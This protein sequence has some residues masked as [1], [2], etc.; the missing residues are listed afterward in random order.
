MLFP[1]LL[2]FDG[3]FLFQKLP[4]EI[5]LERRT[6]PLFFTPNVIS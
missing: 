4:G 5:F 2:Q 6:Q 1:V 3:V